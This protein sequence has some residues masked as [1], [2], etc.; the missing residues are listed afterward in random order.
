MNAGTE[1]IRRDAEALYDGVPGSLF[2]KLR[3][4]ICPFGD[5]I[6]AVPHGARV[7]DVGSGSGLFLGLLARSG[8]LAHGHG[9]DS[10][11]DAIGRAERMRARL[12]DPSLLSFEHRDAAAEWPEGPY[13]VVSIVDVMHHVPPQYQRSVIETAASRLKPGGLL[14]YKDM[15]ERPRWRAWMNRLHDLMLVREWINYVPLESVAGW[16]RGAGLAEQRR[17]RYDMWWYGHELLLLRRPAATK[18]R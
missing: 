13:D 15:V 17:A 2:Q 16:A 1:S 5:L 9:F 3:P 12:A 6:A 11:G 8:R 14:L 7:L 18:A 10:N 4:L